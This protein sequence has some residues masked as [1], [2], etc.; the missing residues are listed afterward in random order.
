[1]DYKLIY[2]PFTVL[3][4]ITLTINVIS[5]CISSPKVICSWCSIDGSPVPL[6]PI[7]NPLSHGNKNNRQLLEKPQLSNEMEFSL[8]PHFVNFALYGELFEGQ[9]INVGCVVLEIINYAIISSYISHTLIILSSYL[10]IRPFCDEIVTAIFILFNTWLYNYHFQL[11]KRT[12]SHHK[13]THNPQHTKYQYKST[14]G[15]IN[16]NKWQRS[17]IRYPKAPQLGSTATHTHTTAQPE[18]LQKKG[19]P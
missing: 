17:T 2:K 13:N 5:V 16:S 9:F 7:A 12:G 11:G 8:S 19:E 10:Y 14:K 3:E 18:E 6:L 4:A 15:L 1:M